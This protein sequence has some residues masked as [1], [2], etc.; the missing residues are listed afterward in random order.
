MSRY[1]FKLYSNFTY[2]LNDP[3]NGD[4]I[5]QNDH[6][7]IQGI[8]TRYSLL[9]TIGNVRSF[10]RIGGT[11]RGDQLNLSVWK[12]QRPYGNNLACFF[13]WI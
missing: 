6:R 11:Y 8:N 2:W 10:T 13:L 4:M 7:T 12:S 1:D 3:V 9:K 5:E